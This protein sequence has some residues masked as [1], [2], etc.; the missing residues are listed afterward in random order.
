MNEQDRYTDP[1]IVFAARAAYLQ[2]LLHIRVKHMLANNAQ[3]KADFSF[4]HE[5]MIERNTVSFKKAVTSF[6]SL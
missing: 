1:D 4:A 5:Y 6:T 2:T 3:Y